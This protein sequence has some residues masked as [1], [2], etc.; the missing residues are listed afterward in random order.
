MPPKEQNVTEWTRVH[1]SPDHIYSAFHF[2]N[3]A[4]E[5]EHTADPRQNKFAIQQH[6]SFVVGSVLASVAFLEAAINELFATAQ[7]H[8]I[9]KEVAQKLRTHW[10]M[11]YFRR[12]ARLLEKY[13]T[14]LDLAGLKPF[15]E[16][17]NPYQNAKLLNDLRNALVHFVPATVPTR[18]AH[19]ARIPLPDDLSQ[20]LNRRF[21][22]NP[23][24]GSTRL[25]FDGE[26]LGSDTPP[27]FPSRCLG[28]GCA[29]WAAR[30][31]LNFADEFFS[32]LGL[33][34]HHEYLRQEL[35]FTNRHK[36]KPKPIPSNTIEIRNTEE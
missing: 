21:P 35:V 2:A 6:R 8:N 36:G 32:R 22:E 34:S 14:A 30:T 19:G 5:T 29:G 12:H 3:L 24:A 23:W 13:Q 16:G 11:E 25:I 17:R 1:L 28:S 27:L 15:D 20:R 31:A 7:D 26:D 9:G 10:S 33:R 4:H 18:A